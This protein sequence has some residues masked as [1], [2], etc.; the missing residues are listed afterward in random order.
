[1]KA[2]DFNVEP[3]DNT[4]DVLEMFKNDVV[5]L[6]AHV[7]SLANSKIR[8]HPAAPPLDVTSGD[9]HCQTAI[10]SAMVRPSEP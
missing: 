1:M 2:L 3:V 7:A 8:H 10:V 6:V 5:V 4:P 9:H